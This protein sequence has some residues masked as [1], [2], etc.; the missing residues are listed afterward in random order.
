ML[1]TVVTNEP[2]NSIQQIFQEEQRNFIK[3]LKKFRS[4]CG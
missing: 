2:D 1:E 4:S 3:T